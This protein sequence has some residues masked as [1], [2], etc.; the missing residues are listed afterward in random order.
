MIALALLK[1]HGLRARLLL[2]HVIH[3]EELVVAE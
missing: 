3:A 1:A 2:R